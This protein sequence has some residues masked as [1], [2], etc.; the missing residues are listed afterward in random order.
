LVLGERL[1]A[2]QR[3]DLLAGILYS[4]LSLLLAVAAVVVK[5]I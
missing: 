5:E 3:V 1:V 2:L 4:A